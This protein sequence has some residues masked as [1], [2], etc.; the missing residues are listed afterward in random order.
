MARIFYKVPYRFFWHKEVLF[1]AS[2]FLLYTAPFFYFSNTIIIYNHTLTQ[3]TIENKLISR[4]STDYFTNY[5]I[6]YRSTYDS[7]Y[8]TC[9]VYSF[10][11]RFFCAS[12][13]MCS[14]FLL[15]LGLTK[16][17][18]YHISHNINLCHDVA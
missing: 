13:T 15:I 12:P 18:F 17:G 2:R 7:A 16:N 1:F 9:T 8:T 4:T 11:F 6:Y 3:K 5:I 14:V 10:F